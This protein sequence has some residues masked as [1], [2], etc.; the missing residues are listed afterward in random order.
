MSVDRKGLFEDPCQHRR[1][2]NLEKQANHG[3]VV[4]LATAVVCW[5]SC[6][7]WRAAAEG[8]DCQLVRRAM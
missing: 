3:E 8:P 2:V 7:C 5:M 4:L 6:I 1:G